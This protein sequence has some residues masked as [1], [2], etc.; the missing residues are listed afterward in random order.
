MKRRLSLALFTCGDIC[1][2]EGPY[3]VSRIWTRAVAGNTLS[4]YYL[5]SSSVALQYYLCIIC[6]MQFLS[7]NSLLS[8]SRRE[9]QNSTFRNST[10][11]NSWVSVLGLFEESEV[12]TIPVSANLLSIGG[13]TSSGSG[14]R[15]WWKSNY[16]CSHAC[17]L[18]FH[19]R[20]IFNL[21]C[22]PKAHLLI[23]KIKRE[24]PSGN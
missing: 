12:W 13:V 21:V 15:Q 18:S 24:K 5:C 6:I 1:H 10:F 2:M 19:P 7:Q 11:R 3:V 23:I 14:T 17:V 9:S 4:L 8:S 20:N 16:M 22:F